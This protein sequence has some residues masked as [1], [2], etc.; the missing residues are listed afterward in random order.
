MALALDLE[1]SIIILDDL[2]ARKIAKNLGCRITGT[3]G[4]IVKASKMG[5]IKEPLQLI[6]E[7]KDNG[8]WISDAVVKKIEEEL[9]LS[10]Y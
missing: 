3:L 4:V 6:K 10:L 1:N 8:F 5:I 2:K 7:L 9:K